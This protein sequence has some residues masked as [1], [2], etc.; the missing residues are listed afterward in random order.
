MTRI[1][2]DPSTFMQ[3]QLAGFLDL[4]AD[5]LVGVRGGV[6]R[7]PVGDSQVA[8][9]AGGG[10]G[11]YPAFCGIVGPGLAAGAVVGNI[12]TS[13]SASDAYSVARAAD[14]GKGVIFAF[15]NYAGDV[16]NFGLATKRL[17]ADGI[18][19]RCVIVT[20]DI[21]S[22]PD[23]KNRRGIA[24]DLHA[25]KVMGAAAA[26]GAD[27]DEVERLGHAA[28]D[29]TRTL[30]VAFSGCTMPG[31]DAP[32]FEVPDGKLG[33]GLGIHGEPGIEDIDMLNADDLGA[34]LVKKVLE[35]TPQGSGTKVTAMLNGLGT[36][37]YEE[38]FLL[39]GV[40]STLLGVEGIEIVQPEVGELVTS[41]DM[42]GCSLTLMWLD[43]EL[44]RLWCA[45][46]YTPAY[47]KSRAPI[48]DLGEVPGVADSAADAVL[49]PMGDVS[50]AA[51]RCAG[52]VGQALQVMERTVREHE[53]ELGRI[54]AVAGDGD[55]GRGMVKGLSAAVAGIGELP[56]G[57]GC[58]VVLRAAGR[59][60][61]DAAGG[62]S[63]VLWGAALE[64]FGESLR[65]DRQ[66]YAP[67]DT[68]DAVDAFSRAI[69]E[70][71]GATPGDKTLI[72]ALEPFAKELRSGVESGKNLRQ[73]WSTAA[74]TATTA[75]KKT[76]ELRPQ[77]GRA[78]P[79][80]EKSVGTPD[81]G[82]T[83]MALLVTALAHVIP[84]ISE[85]DA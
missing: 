28:N 66:S 53:Q 72:D 3:D 17:R 48:A 20:D 50:D 30:G 8:V 6:V 25:F 41:L 67:T 83:S 5:R 26:E 47:R 12:F 57:S 74:Q 1:F 16:M 36:T 78:R 84:D 80:A 54:D 85:V 45:D 51:R 15:G 13:P 79:L 40:V 49:E 56:D 60:F 61:A 44:E 75:A 21:A 11:H 70:L 2:R 9:L 10:S 39:W 62:T 27:I 23:I 81:A 19:A 64:A 37:K 24:G 7:R 52:T 68:V 76:A 58:G 69:T 22:A 73:A 29:A 46:A 35:E 4:Y 65:D 38:L 71:G 63:G 77:K 32:L 59:A 55:H 18:D 42:G 14:Q 33:L 43:E 31:A 34:L 82:A